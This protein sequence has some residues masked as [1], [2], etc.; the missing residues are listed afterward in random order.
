[1]N[2]SGLV[3]FGAVAAYVYLTYEMGGFASSR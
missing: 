1:M 3:D 2:R